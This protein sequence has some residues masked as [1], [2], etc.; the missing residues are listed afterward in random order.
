LEAQHLSVGDEILI[1]GETTGAYEDTLKEIRVQLN[2]VDKVEK[3]TYFSIK[4]NELIRRNDK[5]FKIVP[6]SNKGA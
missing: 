3:G 5:L 4:T 1:T 6:Q 2:P